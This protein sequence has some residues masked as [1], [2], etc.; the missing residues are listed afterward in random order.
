MFNQASS[1]K[2]NV[3]KNLIENLSRI[4]ADQLCILLVVD[5]RPD[6]VATQK[7]EYKV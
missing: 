4:I 7:N 1:G 6:A 2:R 3:S 5:S